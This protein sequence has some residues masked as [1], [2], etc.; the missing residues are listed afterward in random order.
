MTEKE[1]CTIVHKLLNCKKINTWYIAKIVTSDKIALFEVMYPS[2]GNIKI[3][4]PIKKYNAHTFV[5][6]VYRITKDLS[7]FDMGIYI[8]VRPENAEILLHEIN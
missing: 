2:K 6:Q 4:K 8:D 5:Y 7:L 3:R 1:M